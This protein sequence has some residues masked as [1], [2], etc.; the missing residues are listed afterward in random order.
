MERKPSVATVESFAALLTQYSGAVAWAVERDGLHT[1]LNLVPAAFTRNT[2][3]PFQVHL[4]LYTDA[5]PEG[6]AWTSPKS[7]FDRDLRV[8]LGHV[9]GDRLPDG[10]EGFVEVVAVSPRQDLRPQHYNELWLDYHADDGRMHI[11]LPTIQFYGS[12][13]RTL[14]GQNQLWP[15]LVCTER[16]RP[17]LVTINPYREHVDFALTAIAPDGQRLPGTALQLPPK[18]QR[19]WLLADEIP[20][21]ASFL[22]PSQGIGTLLISSSYKMVCYFM[23][24][25]AQ[26]G[27]ISGGDHLAWFYGEKF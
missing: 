24:E 21:L 11:V 27:T 13:K 22:A 14:G 18:S 12:V 7:A 19:R 23:V 20:G 17:S 9:F 16:D 2:R 3:G 8:E 25:N 1:R 6:I 26:T 15:G 4:V 10:F 5:C